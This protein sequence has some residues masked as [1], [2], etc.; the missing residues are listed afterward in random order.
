MK[1]T[2]MI[3]VAMILACGCAAEQSSRDIDRPAEDESSLHLA[4]AVDDFTV[5]LTEIIH[6]PDIANLEKHR[7]VRAQGR[8]LAI[9]LLG[10]LDVIEQQTAGP[11]HTQ[12]FAMAR[13]YLLRFLDALDTPVPA[14]KQSARA[15]LPI[16][17]TPSTEVMDR[18]WMF[19]HFTEILGAFND[20]TG[21]EQVYAKSKRVDFIGQE[22]GRAGIEMQMDWWYLPISIWNDGSLTPEQK[23]MSTKYTMWQNPDWGGGD[24]YVDEYWSWEP[25]YKDEDSPLFTGNLA[26]ALAAEYSI[27]KKP[28]TLRRL[29]QLVDA[30][31]FLDELSNQLEQPLTPND[32]QDGRIQRGPKCRNLYPED[33]PNL[34]TVTYGPD[35]IKTHH[36]NSVPDRETGRERKNVSR[37][38]YYGMLTGYY[39]IFHLFTQM[40][41]LSPEEQTLLDDVIGHCNLIQTY[42]AK[43]NQHP[44]WGLVYNLYAMFEGSC[45]NPPNLSFMGFAAYKG[46]EEIT[47]RPMPGN[48][49]GYAVFT[50]LLDLGVLIGS[51]D[52]AAALFKPAHSGLTAMNQYLG[53][54]FMSDLPR[55]HWEFI[56]PPELIPDF[57]SGRRKLWRRLIAAY[58][59][60]FG[61]FGSVEYE[62]VIQEMLDPG[63]NPPVTIDTIFNS[64]RH[65]H[66]VIEPSGVGIEDMVWPTA[67]VFAAAQNSSTIAGLLNARYDELVTQGVMEFA[68]TDV[69]P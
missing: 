46:L 30:F 6:N 52:L 44:E 62:S 33:E 55:E 15:A 4:A 54:L 57:S 8:P 12:A 25:G 32:G 28:R 63:N 37:D 26:A 50:A 34:M 1:P 7:M 31:G 43:S 20:Q 39:S 27:T 45:A 61:D 23:L 53:A 40:G 19:Y 22:V 58:A 66:A 69:T 3:L 56:F 47:G 13:F 49:P 18:Y 21:Y 9:D 59:L 68:H 35:G 64:I 5:E 16:S 29:R 65:N 48:D 10:R 60:K 2:F 67:F 24:H 17:I 36:N 41:A 51:V 42:L 38:Q 14:Q 11:D